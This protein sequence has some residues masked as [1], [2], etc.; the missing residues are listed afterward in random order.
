MTH[1]TAWGNIVAS[2]S[3]IGPINFDV[4]AFPTRIAGE[5]RDFDP[6]QWIPPKDVARRWTPSSI[7]VSPRS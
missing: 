4:S 7:T 6:A 3:G 2:R 5:V 1:A